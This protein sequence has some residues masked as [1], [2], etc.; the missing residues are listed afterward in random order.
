[1]G[2]VEA[3]LKRLR[4]EE[5]E[6]KDEFLL[7]RARIAGVRARI[8]RLESGDAGASAPEPTRTEQVWS[9]LK[10]S[11]GPMGPKEIAVALREVEPD[12]EENKVRGTLASLKKQGR[13]DTVARGKWVAR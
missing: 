2:K 1:M 13:A 5:T 12:I 6:L 11:D 3:E 10:E 8:R 4:A 7:V 9:V